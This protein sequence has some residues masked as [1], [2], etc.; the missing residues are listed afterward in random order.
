ML[1]FGKNP[2]TPLVYSTRYVLPASEHRNWLATLSDKSVNSPSG[3]V[4]SYEPMM[5]ITL[6]LGLSSVGGA[7]FNVPVSS[8]FCP[9][10]VSYLI[11]AEKLLS[12]YSRHDI[13]QPHS[14][15]KKLYPF[16]WMS[17]TNLTV[18]TGAWGAAE[19]H[20]TNRA[21]AICKLFGQVR[22]R[23][24]WDRSQYWCLIKSLATYRAFFISWIFYIFFFFSSL[25]ILRFPLSRKIRLIRTFVKIFVKNIL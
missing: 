22:L 17:L 14:T 18:S 12:N 16:S 3:D 9:S 7:S 21:N 24:G 23:S 5:S 25:K 10:D 20:A 8:R 2:F 15:Y 13:Q 11:V 6:L 4:N 19:A 1:T